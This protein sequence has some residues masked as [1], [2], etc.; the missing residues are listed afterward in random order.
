[1]VTAPRGGRK[2]PCQNAHELGLAVALHTGHPQYLTGADVEG[3]VLRKP[4]HAFVIGV[5][6]TPRAEK[7]GARRLAVARSVRS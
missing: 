5:A 1:M 4:S 3:D 2:E 7:R 6:K